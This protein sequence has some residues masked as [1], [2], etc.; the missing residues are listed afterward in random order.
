MYANIQ[1]SKMFKIKWMEDFKHYIED[2]AF[3]IW[4]DFV[5]L[6]LNERENINLNLLT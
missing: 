5:N 2:Y 1:R 4:S 3:I 6:K